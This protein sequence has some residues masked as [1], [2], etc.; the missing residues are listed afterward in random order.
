MKTKEGGFSLLELAIVVLVLGLVTTLVWRFLATKLQKKESVAAHSLLERA[1]W[2]LTGYILSHPRLPCPDTDGDG[3][4][5]CPSGTGNLPYRTLGL[6][7]AR[8]GRVRY[9]VLDR[10]T[11][12]NDPEATSG[13]PTPV[14][15]R[16]ANLTQAR[17]RFYP[18]A[19]FMGVFNPNAPDLPGLTTGTPLAGRADTPLSASNIVLGNVNGIDFCQA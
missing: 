6:A 5:N 14:S 10:D 17:D 2:A 18:L 12:V 11:V 9:G 16:D 8:A 15:S 1:D 4:E 13:D 19:G 7:D 3:V